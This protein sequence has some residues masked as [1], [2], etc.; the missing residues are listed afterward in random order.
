MVIERDDLADR[1]RVLELQDGLLLDAEH[2]DVL[3]A[4]PDLFVRE[5]ASTAEK[6]ANRTAQVPFLTASIAYST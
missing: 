6:R 5:D 2:D 1:A 4:H 3:A